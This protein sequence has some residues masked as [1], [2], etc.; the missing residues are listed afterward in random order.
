M[1]LGLYVF[2]E[3]SDEYFYDFIM[4]DFFLILFM[5]VIVK[6]WYLSLGDIFFVNVIVI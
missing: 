2:V 1:V 6:I 5:S 3:L 4:Y